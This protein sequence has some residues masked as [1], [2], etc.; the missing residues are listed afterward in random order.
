MKFGQLLEQ[1]VRNLFLQNHV[2]NKERRLVPDLFVFKKALGTVKASGQHPSFNAPRL[3]HTIK[4][5]FITL[6][7]VEPEICSIL[8]FL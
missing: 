7:T 5:N 1:K 6:Q 8:G 2:E 3:R 4:I